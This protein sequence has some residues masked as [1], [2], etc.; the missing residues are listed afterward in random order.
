MQ[1]S[2][3]ELFNPAIRLFGDN[4]YNCQSLFVLKKIAMS[5]V[6]ILTLNA[7]V[8]HAEV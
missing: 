8:K 3:A 5:S 2:T 6:E 4:M 7:L 1:M